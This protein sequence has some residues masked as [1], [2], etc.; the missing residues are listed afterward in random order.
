MIRFIV[1][2]TFVFSFFE[3]FG[4]NYILPDGEYMDTTS[5]SNSECKV[6]NIYYYQVNGK[7]PESSSSL[8]LEALEFMNKKTTEYTGSGYITFR[9]AIDC[10]GKMANKVQVLQT[11][12]YYKNY[13]FEKSLVNDLYSFVKT[14]DKWKTIKKKDNK[15]YS[16][17]TFITF[18]IKNG[19]VINIIP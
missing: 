13:H 15:T 3:S 8:L 9:F 7:Y 6:N 2:L 18:K 10:E 14:L 5:N 11:N 17:V 12:E 16:Y 1:S 19:K 4:Q